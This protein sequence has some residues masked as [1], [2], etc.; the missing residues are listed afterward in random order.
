MASRSSPTGTYR[1]YVR[2]V[3][4]GGRGFGIVEHDRVIYKSDI[5]A[6]STM[7]CQV[8]GVWLDPSLRGQGLSKPAMAA[9][10]KL[11]RER[12]RVVSLYVNDFNVPARRLYERVGFT[13]V[14]ELA[15]VL[16]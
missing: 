8:Q 3:I 12:H 2:Q 11:A 10:V 1:A 14:G 15:T 4:E 13:T 5:G 6:F 16:Y 9:V 7:F